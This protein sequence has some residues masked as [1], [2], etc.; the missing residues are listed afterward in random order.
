MFKYNVETG[1]FKMVEERLLWTI[2]NVV[3]DKLVGSNE[4]SGSITVIDLK[5]DEIL[6]YDEVISLHD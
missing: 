4:Y 3:G 1:E 6:V 2:Q 5:T